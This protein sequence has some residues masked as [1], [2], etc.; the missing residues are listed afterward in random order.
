MSSRST[1]R[2]AAIPPWQ[3]TS[4]TSS[5]V[6]ECGPR[7][8]A[9]RTS[10]TSSP[11]LGIDDM[12]VQKAMRLVGLER[13]APS[14]PE[15]R[16][17]RCSPPPDRS[18]SRSRWPPPHWRSTRPRSCPHPR[19]TRGQRARSGGRRRRRARGSIGA[20]GSR[21]PDVRW[22]QIG[23]DDESL[24]VGM[25][26]ASIATMHVAAPDTVCRPASDEPRRQV[27]IARRPALRSHQSPAGAARLGRPA[28]ASA[29][30]PGPAR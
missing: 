28:L 6:Y 19:A 1:A 2:C 15:H 18:S 9:S 14:R 3:C 27:S 4:T 23:P 10:S 17:R 5:R 11:S 12:A 21:L 20:C 25:I 16:L 26:R 29:A 30:T 24:G 13:R 22:S 8:T 7:M